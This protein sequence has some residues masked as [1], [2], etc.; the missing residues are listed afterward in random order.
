MP[1]PV[2]EVRDIGGNELV[3]EFYCNGNYNLYREEFKPNY[4][5]MIAMVEEAGQKAYQTFL[6]EYEKKR[7]C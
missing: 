5:Q 6:D 3:A 7:Q 1:R 2:Y 4:E